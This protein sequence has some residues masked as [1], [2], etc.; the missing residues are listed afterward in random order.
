MLSYGDMGIDKHLSNFQPRG[1]IG[2]ES[3]SDSDDYT[4]NR[5]PYF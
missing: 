3:L 5:E 2:H 1:G 4:D